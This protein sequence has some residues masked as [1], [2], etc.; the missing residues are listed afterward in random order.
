MDD[1]PWWFKLRGRREHPLAIGLASA[2]KQL[3]VLRQ[4]RWL[5]PTQTT[6]GTSVQQNSAFDYNSH[7]LR[8]VFGCR[9]EPNVEL[10]APRHMSSWVVVLVW[11]LLVGLLILMVCSLY[12]RLQS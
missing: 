11:S 5:T 10:F 1:S 4:T 12:V 8:L 9:A 3:F 7:S 2:Q 6:K